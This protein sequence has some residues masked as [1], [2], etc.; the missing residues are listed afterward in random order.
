MTLLSSVNP[1][2]ES[3]ACYMVIKKE[4]FLVHAYIYRHIALTILVMTSQH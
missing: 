3:D 4:A 1:Y 2:T